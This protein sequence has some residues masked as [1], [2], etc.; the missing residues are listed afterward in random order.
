VCHRL[1]GWHGAPPASRCV[2]AHADALLILLVIHQVFRNY[3]VNGTGQDTAEHQI[4]GL[5]QAHAEL[6]R[7]Q[8]DV[9]GDRP[10]LAT[11]FWE[12]KN[13]Y[14]MPLSLQ[15]L[16]A[17][18]SILDPARHG[19]DGRR[20]R[21]M[22]SITFGT[23]WDTQVGGSTPGVPIEWC[24]KVA[25]I[26]CSALPVAYNPKFPSYAWTHFATAV[27]QAVYEATFAAAAVLSRE[28][29]NARVKV[30]LTRVGG[31]KLR[32]EL[33]MCS[34]YISPEFIAASLYGR[35]ART[36]IQHTYARGCQVSSATMLA[37]F[38]QPSTLRAADTALTPS[39]STW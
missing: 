2:D 16:Q 35:C 34:F 39:T 8:V 31:G 25:Q 21:F 20:R 22:D 15:H 19:G 11:A 27:L 7:M 24:N 38:R 26:Y 28:R 6:L 37:G 32:D 9:Y 12:M 10:D 5:H 30:F 23:Q 18:S 3:F 33:R 36:R 17:V 1:S 4:N 29:Q 13:G 14:C